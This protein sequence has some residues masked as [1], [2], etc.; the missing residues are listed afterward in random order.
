[1]A[2]AASERRESLPG[3]FDVDNLTGLRSGNHVLQVGVL[4]DR[5]CGIVALFS[6]ALCAALLLVLLFLFAGL[7]SAAFFQLVV[8]L[9]WPKLSVPLVAGTRRALITCAKGRRSVHQG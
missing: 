4:I 2:E 9:T 7:L 3:S 5:S 1:M 8:L 6:F